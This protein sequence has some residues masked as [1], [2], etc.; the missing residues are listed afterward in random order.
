MKRIYITLIALIA[1]TVTGISQTTSNTASPYIF[2]GWESGTR[3][4]G[5]LSTASWCEPSH[6][7]VISST[8]ARTGTYSL[9]TQLDDTDA[10]CTGHMRS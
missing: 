9:R 10:N 3:T 5:V 6:D 1:I 7:A 4:Q 8:Y 2:F